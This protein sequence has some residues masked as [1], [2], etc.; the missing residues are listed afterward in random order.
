MTARGSFIRARRHS[1]SPGTGRTGDQPGEEARLALRLDASYRNLD[2]V[3]TWTANADNKAMIALAF[4]GAILAALASVADQIRDAFA[5]GWGCAL[6]WVLA[7]VGIAFIA[8]FAISL[9]K[10]F[11]TIHPDTTPREKGIEQGSPF[12]FGTIT[13]M[14]L[15]M[16]TAR[17]KALDAAQVQEELIGQ[18]YVISEIAHRKFARL[19]VANRCLLAELALLLV[20]VVIV[21]FL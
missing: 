3:I 20:A 18:T 4:Q 12:F 11:R 17:M 21:A 8:S 1:S 5:T 7:V 9:Y 19:R 15:E 2:R 13:G 16:F 10:L 14:P 6:V